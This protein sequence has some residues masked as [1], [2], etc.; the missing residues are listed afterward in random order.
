MPKLERWIV[1][2]KMIE[3]LDHDI[4]REIL[5]SGGQIGGGWCQVHQ[6]ICVNKD[7]KER[8]EEMLQARGFTVT[9]PKD[10]HVYHA[11]YH[12]EHDHDAQHGH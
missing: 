7:N 10:E 6:H 3:I 8:I 12:Q 5:D 2:H 4:L 9:N 1:A 11:E